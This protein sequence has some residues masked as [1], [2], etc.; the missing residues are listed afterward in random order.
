MRFGATILLTGTLIAC[1][2]G[3]QDVCQQSISV[4][5]DESNKIKS[6]GADNTMAQAG[7]TTLEA[8][9]QSCETGLT[10]CSP[11]ELSDLQDAVTCLGSEVAMMQCNWLTEPDPSSDPAVQSWEAAV[12]NCT[13]KLNGLSVA[14]CRG[15]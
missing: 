11:A 12:M 7:V 13:A 6:C 2:G 10:K 9:E 8:E 15:G 5:Q 3:S 14:A 4:A 1:G